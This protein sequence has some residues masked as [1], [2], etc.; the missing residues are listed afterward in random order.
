MPYKTIQDLPE[1][2]REHIP[3]HA[4]KIFLD[5]YNNA[6][7]E[8]EKPEKRRGNEGREE[9]AFKVAWA[10]VKH[11]YKKDNKSDQWVKKG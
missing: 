7:K 10:A 3:E 6:Y 1:S 11:E 2:V 4:Q 8:Y 5:A 9:A